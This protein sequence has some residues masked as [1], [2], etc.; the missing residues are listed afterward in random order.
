M[1][2]T[3]TS[4]AAEIADQPRVLT[5]RDADQLSVYEAVSRWLNREPSFMHE[6]DPEHHLEE[7][8]LMTMAAEWL[9]R[10][11]PISMHRALLA[12]AMPEQVADAAGTTV[13]DVYEQWEQWAHEQR[14]S[15]VAGRPG[16]TQQAYEAVQ[17]R[18]SADRGSLAT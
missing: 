9:T 11:Q 10:W 14:G 8:A 13:R 4:T 2:S 3:F 7:L 17:A 12:G 1:P 15:I 18:F 16:V 6:D 5:R